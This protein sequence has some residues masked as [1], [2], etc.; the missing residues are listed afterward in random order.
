MLWFERTATSPAWTGV[1]GWLRQTDVWL[2]KHLDVD[3]FVHWL[4]HC[5]RRVALGVGAVVLAIYGVS[6]LTVVAPDEL[7]VVRRFGQPI[8]DVGPGWYLRWPWP[9]EDVVRVSQRTRTVDIGFRNTTDPQK[10]AGALTWNSKHRE[11]R[12][13]DEALMMTGDGNLVD[14]QATIRYRV[15]Q[16]RVFLFGVSEGDEVLRAAGESVLRGTVAGKPFHDLLT[17]YRGR[18]Q[19]EVLARLK[20]RVGAYGGL[21]IEVE[22]IALLDLHPP[23]EVVG[24]YYEVAKAMEGRAQKINEA[25]EQ[26]VQKIKRTEAESQK[27]VAQ[28]RADASEKIHKAGGESARFLA[29]S[30]GRKELDFADEVTLTLEATAAVL[31]GRSVALTTAE[32]HRARTRSQ[33]LQA[34]LTDFRVYWDMLASSLMGRDLVLID[35]DNIKGQRNLFLFDQEQLRVP[36]PMFL[37]PERTGPARAPFRPDEP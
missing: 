30:E 4:G 6:G 26:A 5:W 11:N 3:E 36:V 9:I 8:E 35:A 2:E 7:G 12:V 20:K 18:F 27:I 23:A 32:Q 21:G 15:I 34:A 33:Q 13:A 24:A 25:E 37:P 22:G 31:R 28:A 17:V 16:P 10:G 1:K 29:R 19:D 14:V